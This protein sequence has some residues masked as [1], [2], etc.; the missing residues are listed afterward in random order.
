MISAFD[1][2]IIED[3]KLGITPVQL[4]LKY[5]KEGKDIPS[6]YI[7]FV[8]DCVDNDML[9]FLLDTEDATRDERISSVATTPRQ[10]EA[11]RMRNAG[12]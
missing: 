9:E 4:S 6:T 10:Y 5:E 7:K 3:L 1:Q 12:N 8:K 2:N 11:M